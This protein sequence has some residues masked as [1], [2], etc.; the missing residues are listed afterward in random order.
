M[1]DEKQPD[2]RLALIETAV[3]QLMDGGWAAL[4]MRDLAKSVGISAPSIYHHFAKKSDLGIAMVRYLDAE[5]KKAAD[6]IGASET[7]LL[8]RLLALIAIHDDHEVCARSCPLYNLQAE[9]G[10]LPEEMQE[11]VRDLLRQL[12]VQF[13]DWIVAA[14]EAG[15]ISFSGDSA[16]Q[17]RILISIYEHGFQIQRLLKDDCLEAM[18]RSWYDSV[19]P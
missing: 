14:R 10:I 18:L 7:H 6:S 5:M 4:R 17:A 15:E 11:T 16:I 19:K 9:F 3:G 8:D 13:D 1:S 2:T 12:V